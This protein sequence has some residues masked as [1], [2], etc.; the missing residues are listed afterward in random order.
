ML[1]LLITE[2]DG[3]KRDAELIKEFKEGRKRETHAEGDTTGESRMTTTTLETAA[4][5]QGRR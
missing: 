3:F 1:D 2:H 4:R 5:Y